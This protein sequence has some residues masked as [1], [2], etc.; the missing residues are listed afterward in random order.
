MDALGLIAGALALRTEAFVDL[1]GL[2]VAPLHLG[3]YVVFFGGLSLAVGQS[4]ILF[5]VRVSRR[6]FGFSL[7]LQAVLYV[8]SFLAWSWS[9]WLVGTFAFGGERSYLEVVATIG[10]A[11]AP[12]L[13]GLLALIPYF[14][15]PMQSLLSA[16]TLL[17]TLVATSVLFG[18]SLLPAAV[19]V[20]GGW[21][22]VELAQRLMGRP[23]TSLGV[24][25]RRVVTGTEWRTP[26]VR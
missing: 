26:T 21:L 17:A 15:V 1:L 18:L 4:V 24:W 22:L 14:G 16:W 13:L 12:Q 20:A 5:A 3:L 8:S 19:C 9:V 7:L 2:Q 6:R 11:H 23:F 25:L 10:L